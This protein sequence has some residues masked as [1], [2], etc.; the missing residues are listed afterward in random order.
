MP[1]LSPSKL[2]HILLVGTANTELY[3]SPYRGRGKLNIPPRERYTHGRNILTKLERVRQEAEAAHRKQVAFGID[4]GNGIYLQFESE[5]GF[6]L[7]LE[8]LDVIRSGIELVAVKQLEGKTIATCFVPDGKLI[9]FIKLVSQYLEQDTISGKPRNK[10]LVESISD[11]HKAVLEALWTDTI[12]SF[13]LGNEEIWWEI[14]L[15]VGDNRE[16]Y[17]DF[18]RHH[19]SRMGINVGNQE[20][21]FLDRTVVVAEGNK[22]QMSRSINLLNCIAELRRAKE[23][24]EFFTGLTPTEQYDWIN[25]A[26]NRLNHPPNDSPAICILDTGINNQHPLLAL[27]LPDA[28]MHTYD[29]T[30]HVTDHEGHGTQM[31][32]IALYG[33]LTDLLISTD[34][35]Q[36]GHRLESVKILPPPGANPNPPQLYGAVTAEAIAR[37]EIVAPNRKRVVCMAVSSKDDRDR[38]KPSSWS[39]RL[40][41]LASGADDNQNRLI[42]VAAGNTSFN[43]RRDYPNSNMTDGIH[44]PGQSWNALTVGAFTEKITIDPQ[45]YPGWSCLAPFGDLAPGSCTSIIW[46]KP[47]PT[48]PDIVMEGGNM[49][50]NPGTDTADF[51]DSLSLLTTDR[52]FLIKPLS[53]I[54]DTSPATALCARMAAVI[55]AEYPDYWPETIRGLLVHSAKWTDSMKTHF[56]PLTKKSQ[57][58][59]LMRYCGFGVPDLNEAMWCASNSLTL[60]SQDSLQPFDNIENKGKLRDLNIHSIPWPEEVLQ[61]LDATNVEMKVTLLYFIEPNPGER[62][63]TRRYSYASHGLRFE[64]KTPTETLGQFRSR[65]NKNARD[66]ELGIASS[67][68]A[69]RWLLGQNLRKVGSLHSDLWTG[70]ASELSQRGYIAVYPVIGWWRERLK[71]E[72]WNS[73]ARYS[74]IVTIKT[75]EVQVDLYTPVFNMVTPEIQ[76]EV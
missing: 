36:L 40:D 62:G 34:T 44:D 76:I 61:E 1:E 53:T 4:V 10:A 27:A 66:E 56:A 71:F 16:A 8:S 13:P 54:T 18:F 58:G 28:D 26:L 29:P 37:A 19:A 59:A 21:R 74:L 73:I 45:R 43:S 51:L 50:I 30:W 75:P 15:R 5:P 6:D 3:V 41:A 12:E 46:S 24:A 9:H 68:D 64:V 14:W 48:K 57:I 11:I 42:I 33:D 39:A 25:E 23:T 47:W 69:N 17:L 2:P 31:A 60:I 55:Q 67:S 32:G 7:K 35:I 49:A 20:I 38:G 72:R 52:Q 22:A 63:W 65:I 70:T